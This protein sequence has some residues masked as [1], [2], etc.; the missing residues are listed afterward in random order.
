WSRTGWH[1]C[2]APRGNEVAPLFDAGSTA[3]QVSNHGLL[4]A[5]EGDITLTGRKV[6]QDGVAVATTTVDTRGTIH[7]LASASDKD[8]SITVTQKAL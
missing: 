6:V 2:P 1:R 8:S 3:G 4:R 5:P 7:L